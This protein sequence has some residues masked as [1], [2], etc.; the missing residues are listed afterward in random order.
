MAGPTDD[1]LEQMAR[2]LESP[3]CE[4]K[5]SIS[6]M[7]K[8]EH[9]VCALA[10]DLE[11]SRQP[12]YLLIN[13]DDASGAARDTPITDQMMLTLANLRTNGDILPPPNLT[14]EKRYIG[15][16]PIAVATVMPSLSPPV[17]CACASD[18]SAESR[19]WT[20]SACSPS[21]AVH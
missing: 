10:N 9:V 2:D 19:P 7:R 20:R 15:G 6:D 13:V 5:R 12:G 17:W 4:R 14:V 11:D 1:Q 18:P 8:I 16:L 21:V 3:R